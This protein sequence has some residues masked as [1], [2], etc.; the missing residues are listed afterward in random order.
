[1]IPEMIRKR[2]A[3]RQLERSCCG[4]HVPERVG[5]R[6]IRGSITL[7]PAT[8]IKAWSISRRSARSS[9]V[10][11]RRSNTGAGSSTRAPFQH[12][13]SRHQGAALHRTCGPVIDCRF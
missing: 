10:G 1:M 4:H 2:N 13:D 8:S 6:R 12:S 11:S 5:G 9:P 3:G 7:L